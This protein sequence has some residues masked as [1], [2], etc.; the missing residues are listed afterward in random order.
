MLQCIRTSKHLRVMTMTPNVH[1]EAYDGN[2][3]S[4]EKW[5][6]EGN[7]NNHQDPKFGNT[8][9]LDAIYKCRVGL[10]EFLLEQNANMYLANHAQSTPLYL[11]VA[12]MLQKV[13]DKND[14][15]KN[16][17]AKIIELL[18]INEDKCR[19]KY[20]IKGPYLKDIPCSRGTT[21]LTRLN[22]Y[23]IL[24]KQ[25]ENSIRFIQGND[26]PLQQDICIPSSVANCS[27]TATQFFTN[28]FNNNAKQADS[29]QEHHL[30]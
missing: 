29:Y 12:Q 22:F 13:H 26:D 4:V 14:A 11:A 19:L 20:N 7:D 16:K 18:L 8:L 3:Q 25:I 9:L 10:V 17:Y 28:L 15:Q 5:L 21:P 23:P 1:D 24:K 27:A 2:I 6:A 30:E